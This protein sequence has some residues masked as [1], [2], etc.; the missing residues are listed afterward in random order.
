MLREENE[1]TGSYLGFKWLWLGYIT[2]GVSIA[3]IYPVQTHR[4]IDTLRGPLTR[5]LL[6]I[7][8]AGAAM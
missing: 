6:S 4:W 3:R 1:N 5:S 7:R 8:T 2:Y